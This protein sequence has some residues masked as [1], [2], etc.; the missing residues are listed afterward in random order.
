MGIEIGKVGID[1]DSTI[2]YMVIV[3]KLSLLSYCGCILIASFPCTVQFPIAS[4]TGQKVDME[5][6]G[7]EASTLT[8]LSEFGLCTLHCS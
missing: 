4:K 8:V 6:P 5:R 1:Q 3:R 2:S 7:K